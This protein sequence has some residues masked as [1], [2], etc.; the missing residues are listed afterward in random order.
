MLENMPLYWGLAKF[1]G[2][3]SKEHREIIHQCGTDRSVTSLKMIMNRT[4]QA[5]QGF[6]MTR[7]VAKAIR[8]RKRIRMKLV[9]L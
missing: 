5:G 9:S 2:T 3:L 4:D 8:P 6:V 7:L 1:P